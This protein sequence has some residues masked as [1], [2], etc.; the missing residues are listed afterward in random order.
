LSVVWPRSVKV[1]GK[2]LEYQ[3]TLDVSVWLAPLSPLRFFASD[4]ITGVTGLL[5]LSHAL[6]R[7]G[8]SLL[9]RLFSLLN[10]SGFSH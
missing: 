8:V 7:S 6:P 3:P 4:P 10:L 9:D 2:A 1:K 5:V